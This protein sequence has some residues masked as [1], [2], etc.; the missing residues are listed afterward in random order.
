MSDGEVTR[1]EPGKDKLRSRCSESAM[2]L[3]STKTEITSDWQIKPV[4][5]EPSARPAAQL[6][7]KAVIWGPAKALQPRG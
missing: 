6:S 5:V 1:V 4:S 2:G 7:G 3:E